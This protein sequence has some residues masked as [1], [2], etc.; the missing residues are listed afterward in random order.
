[1][2]QLVLDLGLA[3]PPALDNFLTDLDAEQPALAHLRELLAQPQ[4][5]SVPTLLWGAPGTGKTHLLHAVR[6]ALQQQGQA[7][8]W[9]DAGCRVLPDFDPSWS[10]VLLDDCQHYGSA[11][12]ALAFNWCINALTP[13]DGRPRWVLAAADRPPADLDL[14]PDL[15]TRLAW[16]HV[17]QLPL[18]SDAERRRV[19]RQA[20]S[21]R[22]LLV[23]DELLDFM[24]NRFARELGSLMALLERLDGYAL[25]TQRPLSIP[26]LKAMLDEHR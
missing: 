4:C 16:G 20:A 13:T 22:G 23:P 1:M 10:A 2:Q 9:L 8:G 17:F 14:R 15:R 5:A 7:V 26:L 3:A 21:V 12:Q 18:L 19:L 24:L 11:Q 25:R 6:L